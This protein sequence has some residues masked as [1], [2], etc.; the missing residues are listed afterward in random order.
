MRVVFRYQ[1]LQRSFRRSERPAVNVRHRATERGGRGGRGGGG[2]TENNSLSLTIAEAED[3][4]RGLS[5]KKQKTGK[6]YW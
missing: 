4:A 3:M 5:N 1:S 6:C 2:A